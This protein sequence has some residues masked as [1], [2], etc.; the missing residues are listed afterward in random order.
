MK[1]IY[2]CTIIELNKK[3]S[4]AGNLIAIE[5]FND[6]PFEIKRIYYL[7][8]VPSG[9]SRGGHAHKDLHQMIIATSGSFDIILSDGQIKRTFTLCQPDI[10]LYLPP[11]FWREIENI[12]SGSI[13]LVLASD[14][15]DESDYIRSFENFLIYRKS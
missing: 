13:C 12:S 4:V 6:L 2:D 5:N 15:Y 1:S 10:G 7:Y 8:D 11:G 9:A 14:V 3:K